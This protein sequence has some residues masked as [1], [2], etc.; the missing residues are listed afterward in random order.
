[1]SKA[2][3][4]LNIAFETTFPVGEQWPNVYADER[5]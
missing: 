1:M 4:N 2:D 5:K 3:G